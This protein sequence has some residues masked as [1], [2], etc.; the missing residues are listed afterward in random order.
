MGEPEDGPWRGRGERGAGAPS[1]LQ[2][3]MSEPML[4]RKAPCRLVAGAAGLAGLVGVDAAIGRGAPAVAGSCGCC[5]PSGRPA[6]ICM[7]AHVPSLRGML[8]PKPMSGF[9]C[10]SSSSS[11]ASLRVTRTR[12]SSRRGAPMAKRPGETSLSQFGM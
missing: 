4:M 8:M 7:S 5:G 12:R 3:P 11:R 2:K 1:H 9:A 10:A 6:P